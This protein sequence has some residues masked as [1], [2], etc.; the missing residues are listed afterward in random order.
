M[1]LRVAC[2]VLAVALSVAAPAGGQQPQ[3]GEAIGFAIRALGDEA[4]RGYFF[5]RE[6]QPGARLALP[7]AVTNLTGQPKD[8]ELRAQ[9]AGT[10]GSGG[11][12]YEDLEDGP[13]TWVSPR[14]RL[15]TVAPRASLRVEFTVSVPRDVRPGDHFAGIV[16]YNRSDLEKLDDAPDEQQSVQLQFISR[17]GIPIRVRTPGELLAEVVL[18][19][20][21]LD[22]TPSGASVDVVFRNTGNVLIPESTGR[23]NISQGDVQL[24]TRPLKLTSFLP[25]TDVTVSVPFE[26]A[27]AEATYRA[28]GFLEP[29]FAPVVDFDE[30]VVF[31]GQESEELEDESGVTAIGA[32]GGGVPAWVWGVVGL[33]AVLL[34][35]LLMQSLRTARSRRALGEPP[36]T[37]PAPELSPPA[38][39]LVDLN[40]A[41]LDEL[42]RLPGVGPVAAQR[43]IDHRGEFGGFASVEDLRKVKGFGAERVAALADQATVAG[44]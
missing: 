3:G 25:G 4:T 30:T 24:A 13:G 32:D 6:E 37:P 17:L 28:R 18:D 15:V 34:V 8:I 36:G 11:I 19:D 40:T 41:T 38:A 20:V 44:S 5:F 33:A 26:G 2:A 14:R 10:G 43:I 39:G 35:A 7:I 16:A 1:R 23:V 29:M 12:T 27:P 9:D 31:G 42:M 21:R 22:V